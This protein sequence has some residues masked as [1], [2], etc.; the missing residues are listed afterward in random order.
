MQ[1]MMMESEWKLTSWQDQGTSGS[2]SFCTEPAAQMQDSLALSRGSTI[3]QSARA[4][5]AGLDL[6]SESKRQFRSQTVCL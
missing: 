4:E 2:Q 1:Q 3:L 6:V 5:Q